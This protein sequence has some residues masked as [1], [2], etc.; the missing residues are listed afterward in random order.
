MKT[1][2][3]GICSISASS[4]CHVLSFELG[5]RSQRPTSAIF[6]TVADSATKRTLASIAFMRATTTSRTEPR[7]SRRRWTSSIIRRACE[8]GVRRAHEGG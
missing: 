8:K 4:F 7:F 5:G 6:G 3:D 2:A 1:E